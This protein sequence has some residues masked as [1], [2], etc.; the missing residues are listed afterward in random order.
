MSRY[1]VFFPFGSYADR[2]VA[3]DDFA[4]VE[5]L[6]RRWAPG[7]TVPAE[8]LAHVRATL[9]ASMP[10]PVAM[11]RS[12]GF[13]VDEQEIRVP[14][15]FICGDDDGCAMPL[16]ADG[17]DALFTAGYR[18]ETWT[19]TGH[20]PHLEHPRRT[21]EAVIGGFDAPITPQ[22]APEPAAS[23]GEPEIRRSS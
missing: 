22:L 10:G 14:T 6:W 3:R 23:A 20:F 13:A 12:G 19:G 2:R 1:I 21:A 4:Y 9:A 7:F 18:A 8:H 5:A 16:L 17:Q 15:L 11:Y